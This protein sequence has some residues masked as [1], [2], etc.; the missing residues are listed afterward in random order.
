MLAIS[1]LRLVEL[2]LRDLDNA[3]QADFVSRLSQIEREVRLVEHLLRYGDA[4]ICRLRI[5][6][7]SAHVARDL[8][9]QIAHLLAAPPGAQL[10]L[11]RSRVE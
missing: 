9:A 6:H 5:Q 7:G 11:L 1:R 10:G 4:L 2:R 8:V 3:A